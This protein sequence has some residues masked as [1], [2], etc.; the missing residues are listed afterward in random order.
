MPSAGYVDGL[1]TR[2]APWNASETGSPAIGARACS[3]TLP[4]D[5]GPAGAL[6][7]GMWQWRP[8]GVVATERAGEV[9]HPAVREDPPDRVLVGAAVVAMSASRIALRMSR[10]DGLA[11]ASSIARVTS[12]SDTFEP[13][14]SRRSQSVCAQISPSACTSGTPLTWP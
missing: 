3:V 14:R 9:A 5:D 13:S 11:G 8:G 12:D 2:R 7:G 1:T 4:G 6:V 10:N